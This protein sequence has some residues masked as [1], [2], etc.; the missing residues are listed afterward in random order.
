MNSVH[1]GHTFYWFILNIYIFRLLLIK[2][3]VWLPAF[4]PYKLFIG[5][6]FRHVLHHFLWRLSCPL[7]EVFICSVILERKTVPGNL[8]HQKLW[9]L[10]LSWDFMLSCS[11]AE[12]SMLLVLSSVYFRLHNPPW[13]G[14]VSTFN[15]TWLCVIYWFVW[16]K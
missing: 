5:I 7:V 1:Q 13:F 3:Q 9:P 6:M 15:N 11:R 4:R 12:I 16:L 8:W 10:S 14:W 2:M